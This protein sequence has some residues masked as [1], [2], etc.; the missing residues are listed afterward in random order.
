MFLYKCWTESLFTSLQISDEPFFFPNLPWREEADKGG[1]GLLSWSV[2]VPV[3]P[4]IPNTIFTC[5]PPS[6]ILYNY[7]IIN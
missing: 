4:V 1:E 6:Y 3:V 5:D 7:L 2:P